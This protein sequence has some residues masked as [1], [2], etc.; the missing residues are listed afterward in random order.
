[1]LQNQRIL[2]VGLPPKSHN[3]KIS[4]MQYFSGESS[5]KQLEFKHDSLCQEGGCIKY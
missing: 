5:E 4:N 1:M 3:T 2:Q